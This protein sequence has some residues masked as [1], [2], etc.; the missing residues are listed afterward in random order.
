MGVFRQNNCVQVTCLSSGK[1]VVFEQNLLYS[2]KVVVQPIRYR[3]T[4]WD[5]IVGQIIGQ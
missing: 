2:G 1:V 3:A 4:V 5:G